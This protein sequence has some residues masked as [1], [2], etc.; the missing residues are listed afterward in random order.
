MFEALYQ[1]D[2]HINEK[3]PFSKASDS[4]VNAC[5]F[6]SYFVNNRDAILLSLFI[7]K[8]SQSSYLLAKSA[9]FS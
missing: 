3:K 2:L 7:V 9:H 5:A 4:H 1:I 6:F 8:M